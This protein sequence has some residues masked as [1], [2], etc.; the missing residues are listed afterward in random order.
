MGWAGRLPL[1]RGKPLHIVANFKGFNLSHGIRQTMSK[2]DVLHASLLSA[3]DDRLSGAIHVLGKDGGSAR[4]GKIMLSE[5]EVFGVNYGTMIG[6]AA[7]KALVSLNIDRA[8][9]MKASRCELSERQAG[10]PDM[11]MM[12][13]MVS[14]D[15]AV[16]V[17][18]GIPSDSL[19]SNAF[20]Q[21]KKAT[22][23]KGLLIAEKYP[24]TSRPLDF[25][26]ACKQV[27][28]L[29]HNP[30]VA[31]KAFSSL[32]SEAQTLQAVFD[33]ANPHSAG[34][35]EDVLAVVKG[36]LGAGNSEAQI[37]LILSR[38]D[39]KRDPN[40]LVQDC[41]ALLSTMF[42]TEQVEDLFAEISSRLKSA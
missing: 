16:P 11:A 28:A 30:V 41:K 26:R 6:L 21:L 17:V 5:G 10:T 12:L 1:R 36:A 8:A 39:A 25:V 7:A 34:F 18:V 42:P 32:E 23:A 2:L 33:Q 22:E 20:E 14:S 27:T 19:K 3:R 40:A 15:S 4:S 13:S 29:M 35:R 38:N 37:A 24:P 9:P 31:E